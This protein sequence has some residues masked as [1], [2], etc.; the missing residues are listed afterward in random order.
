MPAAGGAVDA[1]RLGAERPRPHFARNDSSRVYLTTN[2]GLQS[3]TM[4]GYDRRTHLRIT[5]VGPGQQP[6]GRQRD[7]AVARRHARVRQPAGEALTWSA[8][9]RAGRE[10]VEVRIQGRADNTSVPVKRMSLDGGDY[11]DWTADGT[12][13][14]WA[15]GAQFFRQAI[16]AAE[17]QKTDVVVEVPRA[18]P[19]GRCC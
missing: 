16:T 5:G 6:A 3:I 11:L 12:A 17:P 2:R 15:W 7:S 19:R 13:V 8:V 18:A 10:T 4:D 1:G 9:P 14:T